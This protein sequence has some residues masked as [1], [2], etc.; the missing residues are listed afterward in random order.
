[1]PA[2]IFKLSGE[3]NVAKDVD[4]QL[5]DV[6]RVKAFIDAVRGQALTADA[7]SALNAATNLNIEVKMV[8][9]SAKVKTD[10]AAG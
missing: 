3:F 10:E 5:T 8:G 9:R 7:L 1:M 2:Y 4:A 6:A